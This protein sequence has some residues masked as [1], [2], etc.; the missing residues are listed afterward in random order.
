MS[1]V[2]YDIV[3]T[4]WVCRDSRHT[5][6][7]GEY[8]VRLTLRRG[9]PEDTVMH[10]LGHKKYAN[11][12]G[13]S[14]ITVWGSHVSHMQRVSVI[15]Q[16]VHIS[17]ARQYYNRWITY[18]LFILLSRRSLQSP[19]WYPNFVFHVLCYLL[20][21]LY[22]GCYVIQTSQFYRSLLQYSTWCFHFI[23]LR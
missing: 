5:A 14:G 16:L 17:S 18:S 10:S 13:R 21:W 4:L 2:F 6:V 11:V 22:Y 23:V 19:T 9:V 1:V 7:C 12:E 8:L 15:H 20:R 3:D